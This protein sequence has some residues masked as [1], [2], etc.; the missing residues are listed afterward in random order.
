MLVFKSHSILTL[1]IYLSIRK[2]FHHAREYKF[3]TVGLLILFFCMINNKLF[4]VMMNYGNQK[5]YKA[6]NILQS[7]NYAYTTKEK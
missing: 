4:K 7:S 6:T 1:C 2:T 3:V 5:F